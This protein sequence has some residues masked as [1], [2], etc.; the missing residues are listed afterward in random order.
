MIRSVISSSTSTEVTH[1]FEARLP[2]IGTES[3]IE[4]PGSR[5]RISDS[6]V[7]HVVIN[8]LR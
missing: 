7:R 8:D 3:Y 2:Y 6:P 5:S 4:S 1:F